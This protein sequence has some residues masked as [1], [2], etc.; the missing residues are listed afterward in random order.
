MFREIAITQALKAPAA[1]VFAAFLDP[2]KL[3]R[4]FFPDNFSVEEGFI[5][6]HAGGRFYARM[7]N[8]GGIP[9][10]VS[11][12]VLQVESPYRLVFTWRWQAAEFGD[13]L[14][15]VDISIRDEEQGCVLAIRHGPFNAAAFSLH[16][17]GW[18]AALAR[19]PAA[20]A[21]ILA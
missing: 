21:G 1:K 9:V 3:A 10:E 5:E 8:P 2:V 15:T 18:R 7:I 20:L 11:G 14:T 17:A 4:W 12:S 19:L 16:E 13:E 6:G